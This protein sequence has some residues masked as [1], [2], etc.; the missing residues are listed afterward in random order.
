[1]SAPLPGIYFG[2]VTHRR[3]KP[4]AHHLAYDVA[5]VFLEVGTD[6]S[7]AVPGLFSRNAFNLFSLYDRDH[8]AADGRPI[9]EFAW[10]TVR[11]TPGAE[12]VA[13]IYMLFYPRV[14]GYAFNP[15]TTYFCVDADGNTRMMIYEVRNTFGGRQIY[16]TGA[17]APG[18]ENYARVE[19]TFR[20]SPF[21]KIEGDYGLRASEPR[22]TVSVGVALSVRGR[23]VLNAYF[24][25]R[26]KPFTNVQLLRVFFGLP[27]MTAKVIVAI[28]WE[29]LKL[30]KKGLKLQGP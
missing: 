21:N 27:F 3:L 9:S 15:L 10:A 8:G 16:A 23:P 18:A 5:G 30:W 13:R 2:T 24:A 19:K 4:V 28:H 14:L 22:D 1:V 11:A 6:A 7:E 17:V 25:G 12:S 26:R 29:A 20:V